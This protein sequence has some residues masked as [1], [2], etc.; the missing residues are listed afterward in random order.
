MTYS[1]HFKCVDSTGIKGFGDNK[2]TSE[3]WDIP[4]DDAEKLVG[5]NVYFHTTKNDKS[6][7]GGV[8]TKYEVM[9]IDAAHSKRIKIF[10]TATKEAKGIDW[11]GKEHIMAWYSGLVE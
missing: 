2:Y 3:A 5:G 7:F 4:I 6:Y 8:V 10:L 11:N 1:A 9:G